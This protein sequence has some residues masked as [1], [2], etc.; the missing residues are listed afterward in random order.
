MPPRSIAILAVLPFVPASPALACATCGC[1]LSSDAAM[2]YASTAGWQ[3][4]LEYT[5]LDQ[6]QLRQ[7][8]HAV[9]R[10]QAAAINDAG[11]S[12]EVENKTANDYLTLGVGYSPSANWN[13]RMLVPYIHRRHT[14]YGESGNPLTADELSGASF[15]SLGDIKVIASYQGILP[16]HNFGVQFGVKLPTGD[17]GGSNIDTGNTVG[18]HPVAFDSGPN[19]GSVLDTSL[20]AG[21]GSTDLIVGAY[22]Y[23]PVS[24][25]FDAFINGQL[26]SAVKQ[27]L[28]QSG[29]DFRPGN[30]LSVSFGLRYEANANVVPQ[31]QV[32]LTRKSRDHG[33]LA[34]VPNSAGTI[35]YLSPGVTVAV[36]RNTQLYGFVQLPVHSNL[37][38]YQ[39][40]PHWVGTL[41]VSH[42]F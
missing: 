22:Y 1:S 20:Q 42:T 36:A 26:Q 15:S 35:A 11:G 3:V 18:R 9:F 27:Q 16:T 39:L 19:A 38:G 28:N 7:G 31:V 21:T 13:F 30:L 25:D 40:F 12:Q 29:A 14:T 23:Q 17:Y 8:T 37:E 5:Y 2:G 4:G 10:A 33:A 41:G 6:S 32:N 34:D 24:Q